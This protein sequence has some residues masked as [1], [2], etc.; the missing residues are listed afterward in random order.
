MSVTSHNLFDSLCETGVISPEAIAPFQNRKPSA[1]Q[2]ATVDSLLGEL[3]NA[4]LLTEFQADA[5]RQGNC[6]A[7]IVGDFLIQAPLAAPAESPGALYP[8]AGRLFQAVHR[9]TGQLF[10]L[11]VCAPH[12]QVCQEAPPQHPHL[13]AWQE[14]RRAPHAVY[15][16]LS[17]ADTQGDDLFT[18]VHQ[19][20]PIPLEEALRAA[21]E[22]ALGLEC[23]AGSGWSLQAF[24]A[25]HLILDPQGVT[26]VVAAACYANDSPVSASRCIRSLG[27][28]LRF[29]LTGVECPAETCQTP[30]DCPESVAQFL[31]RLTAESP[32]YHA[33][34]PIIAQL[35]HFLAGGEDLADPPN[36]EL[37]DSAVAKTDEAPLVTPPEN[38]VEASSSVGSEMDELP[39]APS[40]TLST[41]TAETSIP[42]NVI[43]ESSS[44]APH[45]TEIADEETPCQTLPADA[46]TSD[47]ASQDVLPESTAPTETAESADADEEST[48]EPPAALTIQAIAADCESAEAGPTT[49]SEVCSP[50]SASDEAAQSSEPSEALSRPTP[51][52]ANRPTVSAEA[53]A[54]EEPVLARIAT[55]EPTAAREQPETAES[56]LQNKWTMVGGASVAVLLLVA[57]LVML[58]GR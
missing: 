34:P 23:L 11:F 37:V 31:Q 7:L 43:A 40:E 17:E 55:P 16:V 52:A 47:A 57:L 56:L 26:R 36:V 35:A 24:D 6:D 53:N 44:A 46:V 22:T 5:I 14:C 41:S 48:A 8:A 25:S 39:P 45:T 18:V 27:R 19:Y 29:L 4:D 32:V 3:L 20:G 10:P 51:A 49:E 30:Q 2:P 54:P 15:W 1:Q 50:A 28:V 21:H 58:F 12:R 38:E 33:F 42:E 9:S 13:V